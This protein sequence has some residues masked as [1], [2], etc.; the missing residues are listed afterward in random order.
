[1]LGFTGPRV[2]TGVDPLDEM[3][4]GFTVNCWIKYQGPSY[5]ERLLIDAAND[6]YWAPSAVWGDRG[7]TAMGTDTQGIFLWVPGRV[8]T[9]A[10]Y[11]AYNLG[12]LPNGAQQADFLHA[13]SLLEIPT[14]TFNMGGSVATQCTYN[15]AYD[16]WYM[17][18]CSYLPLGVL[19]VGRGTMKMYVDGV[20]RMTTERLNRGDAVHAA[21]NIGSLGFLDG[22]ARTRYAAW[23]GN[24]DEVAVW[25]RVL[26]QEQVWALYESDANDSDELAH[27]GGKL[28]VHGIARG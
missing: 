22:D 6:A 18:T 14:L 17:V 5:W 20:L 24:I 8:I 15:I 21:F 7:L 2:T 28:F 16:R 4:N 10:D 3:P 12:S 25:D 26:T 23:Y 9:N 11:A 1:M 13:V 19:S 27:M